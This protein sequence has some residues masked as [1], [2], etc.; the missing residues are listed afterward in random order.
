MTARQFKLD[1]MLHN[2]SRNGVKHSV[3]IRKGNGSALKNRMKVVL[4]A[5]AP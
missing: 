1:F 2:C 5:N 3:V 4:T